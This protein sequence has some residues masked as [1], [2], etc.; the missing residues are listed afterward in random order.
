MHQHINEEIARL[1]DDSLRSGPATTIS[2]HFFD[3][4]PGAPELEAAIRGLADPPLPDKA[5]LG[6]SARTG[7]VYI[8]VWWDEPPLNK[9][10]RSCD[11]VYRWFDV[12]GWQDGTLA[13]IPPRHARVEGM[14]GPWRPGK[15]P[16]RSA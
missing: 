4:T 3:F 7:Q 14:G 12:T 13:E 15:A 2:T 10:R 9:R 6:L 5:C 1:R 8:E 16:A 11:R